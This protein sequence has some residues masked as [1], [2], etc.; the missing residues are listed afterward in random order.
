M[1][2]ARYPNGLAAKD[3][4]ES[5]TNP[6]IYF[7]VVTAYGILRKQGVPLGKFDYLGPFLPTPL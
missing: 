1:L 4:C 5:L 2:A 6:N 7:H 3:I